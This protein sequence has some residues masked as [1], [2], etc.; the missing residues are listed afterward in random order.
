MRRLLMLVAI[1]CTLVAAQ[2]TEAAGPR[3]RNRPPVYLSQQGQWARQYYPQYY[4]NI[5]ARALQNIGIPPGDVGIRGNG[6]VGVGW[7]P[8]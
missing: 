7:N 5:H 6:G 1:G 8:W 3:W 4:G 2:S